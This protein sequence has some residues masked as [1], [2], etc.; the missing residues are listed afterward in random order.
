MTNKTNQK[1]FAAILI[2]IIV[3]VIVAV[4]A[5]FLPTQK[6]TQQTTQNVPAIQS[7]D[8]L[9]TVTSDLDN[10]DMNQFDEELNQLDADSSEF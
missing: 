3:L 2:I 1:G 4:V 5:I 9:N 8:D 10:T 7:A 6:G